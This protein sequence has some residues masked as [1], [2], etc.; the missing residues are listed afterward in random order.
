MQNAQQRRTKEIRSNIRPR[1][2]D[3]L[4]NGLNHAQQEADGCHACTLSRIRKE[5]SLELHYV[6]G[7]SATATEKQ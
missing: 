5:R 4:T 3:A 1:R 6:K 2:P 7:S